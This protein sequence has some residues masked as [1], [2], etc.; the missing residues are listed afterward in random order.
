MT[1]IRELQRR[2]VLRVAGPYLVGAWL[3]VQVAPGLDTLAT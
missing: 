3:V 2:N 1:F